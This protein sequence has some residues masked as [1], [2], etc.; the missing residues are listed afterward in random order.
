MPRSRWRRRHL[1]NRVHDRAESVGGRVVCDDRSRWFRRQTR[2]DPREVKLG[3]ARLGKDGLDA[4]VVHREPPRAGGVTAGGVDVVWAVDSATD[5]IRAY[6]SMDSPELLKREARLAQRDDDPTSRIARP[7]LV[8][9]VADLTEW[10]E[11]IQCPG[12]L[13]VRVDVEAHHLATNEV[14]LKAVAPQVETSHPGSAHPLRVV[15]IGKAHGIAHIGP[16]ERGDDLLP[17]GRDRLA[18]PAVVAFCRVLRINEESIRPE[19]KDVEGL[20]GRLVRVST[21][22]RR[23]ITLFVCFHDC[24]PHDPATCTPWKVARGRG[25]NLLC[26][27]VRATWTF[28][29][30]CGSDSKQRLGPTGDCCPARW[31]LA[32]RSGGRRPRS[33]RRQARQC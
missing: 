29:C 10:T 22:R 9:R 3:A 12:Y 5:E 23:I 16:R 2:Q 31:S 27:L 33:P 21:H 7:V 25:S 11:G 6:G 1:A 30:G 20:R 13:A 14:L 26:A 18:Y 24:A 4:G 17:R 28:G 15:R 8:G 19:E 32:W